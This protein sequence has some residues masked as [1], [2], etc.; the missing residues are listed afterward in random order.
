[1]STAFSFTSAPI[2]T[3]STGTYCAF[4]VSSIPSPSS[5]TTS[6]VNTVPGFE[7]VILQNRQLLSTGLV[8]SDFQYPF[9]NYTVDTVGYCVARLVGSAPS[10]ADKLIC[11]NGYQNALDQDIIT[12]PGAFSNSFSLDPAKGVLELIPAYRYT[13][14]ALGTPAPAAFPQGLI[15]LLGTRNNT[16][17]FANPATD[18]RLYAWRAS[19]GSLFNGI[20][21]R[22]NGNDGAL[23][24]ILDT[25][26][27]RIRVGK[28]LVRVNA[29]ALTGVTWY[30]SNS[31][32]ELSLTTGTVNEVY[33][34]TSEWTALTTPTNCPPNAWTSLQS[35][36]TTTFWNYLKYECTGNTNNSITTVEFSESTWQSTKINMVP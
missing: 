34:D 28:I 11:F 15:Y 17:A 8:F 33:N 23:N 16:I 4:P 21:D 2:S 29:N 22:T 32:P 10:I 1:M 19:D 18:T 6:E 30:G 27:N 5:V 12:P 13:S 31:I 36:D 9:F 7:P 20:Y 35:N 26:I 14:G 25:R 3:L 24:H